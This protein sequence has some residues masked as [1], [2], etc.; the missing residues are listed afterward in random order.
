MNDWRRLAKSLPRHAPLAVWARR[1]GLHRITVQKIVAGNREVANGPGASRLLSLLDSLERG[2]WRF[3]DAP[4]NCAK[5]WKW[6][7]HAPFEH[8]PGFRVQIGSTNPS[9]TL[10]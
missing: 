6:E 1:A 5:S 8:R 2:E 10:T 7:G 9:L 3:L 4:R